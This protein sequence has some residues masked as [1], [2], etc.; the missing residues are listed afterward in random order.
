VTTSRTLIVAGAGIG[1]LTAA[2]AL[3]A[4]G[5]RVKVLEQAERLEETG[6]GI[7]LSPNATRVLLALGLET[8]LRAQIVV[9][10]R[11]VVRAASSGREIVCMPLGDAAHRRY[12]APY[13]VIHRADL[14]TILAEAA[15]DNPEVTVQLGTAV[16]GFVTQPG[17][18]AVYARRR[19]GILLEERGIGL[20]GADGLWSTVRGLIEKPAPPRFR[21]RVAWRAS[22]PAAEVADDFRAP[23]VQL[24]LGHGAHL[25]HYPV[26]AGAL[27][28]IV[29]IARDGWHG[30][31]FGEPGTREE[32]LG[33]FRRSSWAKTAR[34]L[35]AVP[36]RWLKW[37]LFDRP[38]LHASGNSNAPVTLLGDA[39]H[40]MLPFLAQ[41]GAMAIEDAGA[42]ADALAA[43]PDDPAPAMR[44]YEALRG[45][46][47]QRMADTA[48]RTGA[49]YE[50]FGP[51]AL[52]RDTLM[53]ALG[54]ERLLARQDWVYAYTIGQQ[55]ERALSSQ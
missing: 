30:P 47:T 27:L 51:A 46:R 1:G 21:H 33:R 12:R 38:P 13:W 40:P 53:R 22:V 10:E 52:M 29:A 37:A 14:Q 8:K 31:G 36:E 19:G 35:L 3:A 4:K 54:G 24:W 42:L 41:G 9:P 45:P 25:V 49:I 23:V 16:K 55:V 18:V 32:V 7:Q 44:R 43:R 26:K 50:L 28:N 39:A 17:G 11:L 2:L 34:D 20:V 6:A 15:Q 48:R 5:F